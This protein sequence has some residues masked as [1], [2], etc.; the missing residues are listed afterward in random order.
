MIVDRD[1]G[2]AGSHVVVLLAWQAREGGFGELCEARF[3]SFQAFSRPFRV[4][5][6]CPWARIW[7]KKPTRSAGGR[8]CAR[9]SRPYHWSSC[10]RRCWA[11]LGGL[12]DLYKG[13]EMASEMDRDVKSTSAIFLSKDSKSPGG[14]PRA[15]EKAPR[16]ALRRLVEA[17]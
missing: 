8:C 6:R 12:D 3:R 2:G 16:D 1:S 11:R 4:V 14:E 17:L 13:L 10:C 9:G 15:K 5:R 7:P